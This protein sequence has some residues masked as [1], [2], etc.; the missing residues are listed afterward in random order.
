MGMLAVS[1][2]SLFTFMRGPKGRKRSSLRNSC[3]CSPRKVSSYSVPLSFSVRAMPAV[4]KR[5]WEQWRKE[6][7]LTNTHMWTRTSKATFQ[8]NLKLKDK[9]YKNK[10]TNVQRDKREERHQDYECRHSKACQISWWKN[11]EERNTLLL[12]GSWDVG[13]SVRFVSTFVF[14][15]CQ[16]SCVWANLQNWS[17]VRVGNI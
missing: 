12:S 10:H 11:P 7:I 1:T 4:M 9:Y 6:T 2:S 8:R 17:K 15:C 3:F 14:G 13:F 16:R 5:H